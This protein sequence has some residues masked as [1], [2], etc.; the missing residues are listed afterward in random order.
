[1]SKE[2]KLYTLREVQKILGCTSGRLEQLR[3]ER[4]LAYIPGA[5]IMILQ[6]DLDDYLAREASKKARANGYK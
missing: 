6:E 1:M 3:Y 5:P 2:I 4:E